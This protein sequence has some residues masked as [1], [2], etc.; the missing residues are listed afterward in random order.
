MSVE[1]LLIPLGIAVAAAW[2]ESRSTD[3]CEKCKSTRITDQTLLAEALHVM[4]GHHIV[5][6]EGRVTATTSFGQV[7]FQRI[8]EIFLGRVDRDERA[9]DRMLT[10][11][12]QAVGRVVQARSVALVRQHAQQLGL[13]LVTEQADDGTIQLVFEEQR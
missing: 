3:L 5:Q 7:T 13:Q 9:T 11:L 1:V 6:V 4:G 12:E 8:G 2:R 10:A